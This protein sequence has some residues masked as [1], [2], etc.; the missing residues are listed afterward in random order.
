MAKAIVVEDA[1]LVHA[2][3]VARVT[4]KENGSR[5][6]ALLLCFF[7]TGMKPTELSQ[8]LVSD[9]LSPGGETLAETVVRAEIA[10]NG[11]PRP[12]CW[13]NQKLIKAVDKHLADRIRLGYGITGK[14]TA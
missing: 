13:V 10:F 9:Y 2:V 12:L 5:D 6:A 14:V 4:S 8:L 11:R 7:G 1:Q 3:A